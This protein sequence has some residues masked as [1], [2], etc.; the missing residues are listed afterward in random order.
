MKLLIIIGIVSI[1]IGILCV[2]FYLLMQIYD[3]PI[4]KYNLKDLIEPNDIIF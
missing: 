1:S 4:E 2:F 3:K